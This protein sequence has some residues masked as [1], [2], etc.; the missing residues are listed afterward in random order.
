MAGDDI[1]FEVRSKYIESLTDAEYTKLIEQLTK[2]PELQ[3]ILGL[4]LEEG[5]RRYEN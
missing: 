5:E 2:N 1:D 3:T 4:S